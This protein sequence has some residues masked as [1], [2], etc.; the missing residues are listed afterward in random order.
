MSC[1][2]TAGSLVSNGMRGPLSGANHHQDSTAC[3]RPARAELIVACAHLFLLEIWAQPAL[4]FGSSAGSQLLC[5]TL[6]VTA[7]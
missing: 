5:E 4:K 1:H 6:D 7:I 3:S 2:S